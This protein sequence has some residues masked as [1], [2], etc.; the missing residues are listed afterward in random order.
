MGK[1]RRVLNMHRRIQTLQTSLGGRELLG[2]SR[3]EARKWWA[4]IVLYLYTH[5]Y[6][7]NFVQVCNIIK[8]Y[9][10]VTQYVLT[11]REPTCEYSVSYTGELA[12]FGAGAIGHVY[13][14]L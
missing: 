12:A 7:L 1:E 9:K 3:E 10:S 13:S 14:H 5:S 6:C 8:V 4:L 2:V 11:F